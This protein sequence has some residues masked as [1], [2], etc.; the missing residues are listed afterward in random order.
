[1]NE[2]F[3]LSC[4]KP[5]H[6]GETSCPNCGQFT[7]APLSADNSLGNS[8]GGGFRSSFVTYKTKHFPISTTDQ[9]Y[10]EEIIEILGLVFVS[11]SRTMA[12]SSSNAVSNAFQDGV[13]LLEQKAREMGADQVAIHQACPLSVVARYEYRWRVRPSST[14]NLIALI[15]HRDE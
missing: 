3:C 6:K 2:S 15:T 13:R 1:M 7:S 11:S 8:R 9:I 10:G 12:L 5:L 14:I 4:L